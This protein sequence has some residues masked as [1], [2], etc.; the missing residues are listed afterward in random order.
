MGITSLEK[1]EYPDASN[2]SS[3]ELTTISC[4]SPFTKGETFSAFW[5]FPWIKGFREV[6]D[7]SPGGKVDSEGMEW[8]GRGAHQE[9]RRAKAHSWRAAG[10]CMPREEGSFEFGVSVFPGEKQ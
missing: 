10:I 2:F 1:F 8:A 7:D 9:K 5:N 4:S 6:A 3:D